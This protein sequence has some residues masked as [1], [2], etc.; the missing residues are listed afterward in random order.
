MEM[1]HFGLWGSLGIFLKL[2]HIHWK[3]VGVRRHVYI[4]EYT[5]GRTDAFGKED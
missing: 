2:S 3:E 5:D 1:I 4:A